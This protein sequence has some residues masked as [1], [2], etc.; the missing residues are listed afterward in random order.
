MHTKPNHWHLSAGTVTEHDLLAPMTSTLTRAAAADY[1]LLG[2][3]G[4]AA[5][6]YII[7]TLRCNTA[8]WV[9]GWKKR[10][11]SLSSPNLAICAQQQRE[12]QS[13]NYS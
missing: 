6:V 8:G 9:G 7:I 2:L 13:A 11:L 5:C 1:S 4:L 3:A 12:M 10:D